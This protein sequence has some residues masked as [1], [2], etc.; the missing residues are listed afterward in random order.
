MYIDIDIIV[1]YIYIILRACSCAHMCF[2]ILFGY[3]VQYIFI[4]LKRQIYMSMWFFVSWVPILYTEVQNFTKEVQCLFVKWTD[5]HLRYGNIDNPDQRIAQDIGRG[6][7]WRWLW[8]AWNSW[9]ML[10]VRMLICNTVRLSVRHT[11]RGRP[12][13]GVWILTGH[14][15]HTRNDPDWFGIW[16]LENPKSANDSMML[17]TRNANVGRPWRATLSA[18]TFAVN[19]IDAIWRQDFWPGCNHVYHHYPEPTM[20]SLINQE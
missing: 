9:H 1:T 5:A 16:L 17:V 18:A 7:Q 11:H 10:Y 14:K 20:I 3:S 4:C 15:G 19:A 13:Q 12:S 6:Q 2:K 8:L